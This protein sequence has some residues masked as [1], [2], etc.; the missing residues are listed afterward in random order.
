MRLP[1]V[2]TSALMVASASRLLGQSSAELEASGEAAWAAGDRRSARVAYEALVQRDSFAVPAALLRLGVLYGW[3][4]DVR[5]ALAAHRAYV[6]HFPR[7]A[8]GRSAFG[9][10]LAWASWFAPALA[11]YDSALTIEPDSRE[12][13]LGRASVL[14]WSGRVRDAIDVL[15]R[16]ER[17]HPRDVEGIV[18]R[19]RFLSW[20]GRSGA[21][22]A[23]V[24]SLGGRSAGASM[25]ADAREQW[26]W[27]EAEVA[28]MAS[29]RLVSSEDSEKNRLEA[30]DLTVRLGLSGAMRYDA[31]ARV[32]QVSRAGGATPARTL[33]SFGAAVT[34]QPLPAEYSLRAEIGVTDFGATSAARQALTGEF[35]FAHPVAA[36]G[37]VGA[38]LS[39]AAFDDILSAA[40]LALT[41]DDAVVD[42]SLPL[43]PALM[44]SA[45][46]G[47]GSVRGEGDANRRVQ[48]S[49]ELRWVPWR[50][51]SLRLSHREVAWDRGAPGIHFAPARFALSEVAAAW[52]L[53]RD[54]GLVLGADAG[55]GSQ[56]VRF[57]GSAAAT[58]FAP[59][60][61]VRFGW[62]GAPGREIVVSLLWAAAAAAGTEV[63]EDYR[64][65]VA[66]LGARWTF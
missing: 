34:W 62:K 10:S 11:Q 58:R 38:T 8:V 17:S 15:E 37:F 7:D 3:A 16:W 12:A 25:T 46:G 29:A 42:L 57:S 13:T 36:G 20:R 51:S 41:L 66:T 19:A 40:D 23:L 1:L 26:R 48:G 35:R 63:A 60:G 27:V 45:V 65:Q 56:V 64:A 24:D 55:L 43:G 49:A 44:V 22:D 18:Q 5:G 14:A 6:A 4:G 50:R 9:R 53:P 21:L 61:A 30:L 31:R 2:V 32:K 54:L 33:P 52:E 59:R 39:R 47:V 28:P